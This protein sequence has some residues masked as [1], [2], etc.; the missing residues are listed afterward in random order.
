MA[1]LLLVLPLSGIPQDQAGG[2][3][4]TDPYTE[5]V[6]RVQER[7]H[8]NGYDIGAVDGVLDMRTQ[9]A[10]AQ[11]QLSRNLP[12]GA[13]MDDETLRELGVDTIDWQLLKAESAAPTRAEAESAAAGEST[14]STK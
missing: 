5:L 10:L 13:Q 14:P 2:A 6:K 4:P 3:K 9:R 1:V 8:A 7:L 11:F 12:A